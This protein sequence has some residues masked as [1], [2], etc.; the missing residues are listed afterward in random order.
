LSSSTC[1]GESEVAIVVPLQQ[2]FEPGAK[3]D[4]ELTSTS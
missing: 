2:T 4:E 3:S 1:V